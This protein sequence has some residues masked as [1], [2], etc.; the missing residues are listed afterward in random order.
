MLDFDP[1]RAREKTMADLAASLT[2]ADLHNLTDEMIDEMLAILSSAQDADVVFLPSDPEANDRF[3]ASD[4]EVN[5]PWTL[6]HVVVHTTASAEE[7]AALAL[8]LARGLEVEGRSRYEVPWQTVT[9][10]TQCRERLEESRRM[11]HAMLNAWP[12]SP[13]LE[14]MFLATYPGAVPVNATGR[15]IGGLFHD[16]NHLGQLRQILEQAHSR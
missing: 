10:I 3:A 2:P 11:R 7:A 12:A 1:V 9:T 14:V 15:F 8:S 13:H 4:S 16:D 6:G 5:I